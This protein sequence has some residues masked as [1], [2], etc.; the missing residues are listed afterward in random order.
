MNWSGDGP[1]QAPISSPEQSVV[2]GQQHVLGR[3]LILSMHLTTTRSSFE[4]INYF[5]QLPA[6][7]QDDDGE[8]DI[9]ASTWWSLPGMSVLS[10]S[11]D[12]QSDVF[13]LYLSVLKMPGQP[14]TAST[15]C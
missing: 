12:L 8:V 9:R 1:K 5:R 6:H 14:S 3:Q 13:E 15:P 11:A 10:E 7:A 2:A 4:A